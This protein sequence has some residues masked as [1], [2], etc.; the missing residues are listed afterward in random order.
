MEVDVLRNA[1]AAANR[2]IH[3][4]S[5]ELAAHVQRNPAGAKSGVNHG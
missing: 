1:I 3:S 2:A 4:M 5:Y